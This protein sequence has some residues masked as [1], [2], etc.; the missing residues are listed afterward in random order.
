MD[1]LNEPEQENN[2]AANSFFAGSCGS[3]SEQQLCISM[4]GHEI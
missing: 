4:K 3:Q 1:L 2:S